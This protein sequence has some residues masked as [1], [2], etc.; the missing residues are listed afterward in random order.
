[1]KL[2]LFELRRFN[3]ALLSRLALIVLTLIPLLYGALYLAAFWDPYGNLDKI[4][5]ALVNEDRPAGDVHAGRDLTSELL[6]R[7]VFGWHVTDEKDAE[8]GLES[9]RYHLISRIPSDFSAAVAG[10]PDPAKTP[11]KGRLEVIDN[12][13]TNYLSGLLARTAFTEIRT[14]AEHSAAARYFDRMLI[15]FTDLKAKTQEAANGAGQLAS[16]AG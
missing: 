10:N 2:A 13:A 16:G 4:P 1:M 3:R 5:V 7:H 8:R 14:A 9:G 6:A 12:D 11:A 15:G